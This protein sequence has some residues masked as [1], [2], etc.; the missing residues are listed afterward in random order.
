MHPFYVCLSLYR[1]QR[2]FWAHLTNAFSIR[3][4]IQ[5][6]ITTGWLFVGFQSN[7]L[8][9]FVKW[10]NSTYVNGRNCHLDTAHGV[11][12]KYSGLRF[13]GTFIRLWF[14]WHRHART[15]K[16]LFVKSYDLLFQGVTIVALIDICLYWIKGIPCGNVIRSGR[17]PSGSQRLAADFPRD[18][19]QTVS[20][21]TTKYS[22]HMYVSLY[23]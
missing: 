5:C 16:Q 1:L 13:S 7:L 23:T 8:H 6:K 11:F 9:I 14:G 20:H 10:N 17:H 4:Q 15:G 19:C 22:Y 21:K 3:I 2:F 18:I 12:N